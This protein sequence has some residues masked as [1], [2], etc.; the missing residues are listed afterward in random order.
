MTSVVNK[1][2]PISAQMGLE[3][4]ALTLKGQHFRHN[5]QHFSLNG[6]SLVKVAK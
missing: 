3:N 1:C 2:K 5:K 6:Y 4:S